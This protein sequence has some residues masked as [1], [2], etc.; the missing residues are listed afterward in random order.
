VGGLKRGKWG[1]VQSALLWG[2]GVHNEGHGEVGKGDEA[3]KKKRVKGETAK[4]LREKKTPTFGDTAAGL[5]PREAEL[6]AW[7]K[8]RGALQVRKERRV[9]RNLAM[10]MGHAWGGGS[11]G[12]GGKGRYGGGGRPKKKGNGEGRK[13]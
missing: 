2:G 11:G 10:T 13:G 8:K 5:P 1:Y 3:P 4:G 6:G 12:R 7:S 9:L